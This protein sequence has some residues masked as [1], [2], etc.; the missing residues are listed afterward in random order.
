MIQTQRFDLF[1]VDSLSDFPWFKEM[2]VKLF[3]NEEGQQ[4]LYFFNQIMI[5][6]PISFKGISLQELSY[7]D[8]FFHLIREINSAIVKFKEENKHA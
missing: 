3:N 8:G 4:F 5:H 7:R 2:A 6:N 1:E